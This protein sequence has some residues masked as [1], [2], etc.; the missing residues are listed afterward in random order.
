MEN[1]QSTILTD[2]AMK[3]VRLNRFPVSLEESIRAIVDNC[4]V[5]QRGSYRIARYIDVYDGESD[6]AEDLSQEAMDQIT[7]HYYGKDTWGLGEVAACTRPSSQMP[8]A[9]ISDIT[10]FAHHTLAV[11]TTAYGLGQI[12]VSYE[13]SS[14]TDAGELE[15]LD[16][17]GRFH[18]HW[19]LCWGKNARTGGGKLF[20]V[21]YLSE[22]QL[23]IDVCLILPSVS[24]AALTAEVFENFASRDQFRWGPQV[25][26]S[27]TL[28]TSVRNI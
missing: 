19:S 13:F 18:L 28:L 27:P 22:P 23:L 8:R 9:S 3:T 7:V 11:I 25:G 4:A 21:P 15:L 16:E 1:M 20:S 6:A 24:L 12:R 26:A 17:K 14:K 5:V 2:P 10:A